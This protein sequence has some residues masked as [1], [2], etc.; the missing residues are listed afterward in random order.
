MKV[1]AEQP[2]PFEHTLT[3]AFRFWITP[4]IERRRNAGEID[5]G[6]ILTAAQV[7]FGDGG[8]PT[9]RLNGEVQG[10]LQARG[11]RAVEAGEP[12][13]SEDLAEIVGMELMDGDRDSGH[14]TIFRQGDAWALTFNFNRNRQYATD[15]ITLGEQF[16]RT[17]EFCK[18]ERLEGPYIDN[19]FSACELLA[20]A[21][22]ITT[23]LD[24]RAR[25]HRLIA[26][27]IN[28]W[29]SLGNVGDEFVD[30]F[31]KVRDL[32]PRARYAPDSLEVLSNADADLK[33]ARA[34]IELLRERYSPKWAAEARK[35]LAGFG[36]V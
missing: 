25:G 4:E 8:P 23:A 10:F 3:Q 2:N 30:L 31:N 18:S 26:N 27:T 36:Q 28:R 7:L 20:K 22:L 33:I 19:L 35:K 12:V 21:H 16:V 29:R 11:V 13:R 15:L 34:E 17:A 14:F 32:R 6:F 5:E 9:V 1:E 24:K